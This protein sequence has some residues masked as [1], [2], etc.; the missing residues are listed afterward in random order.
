MWK[1]MTIFINVMNM[2][3]K[4][5]KEWPTP[6]TRRLLQEFFKE[7]NCVKCFKTDLDMHPYKLQMLREL[8]LPDSNIVSGSNI[9]DNDVLSW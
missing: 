5:V 3:R 6:L 4:A 9:N 8:L 7:F 1:V 2:V